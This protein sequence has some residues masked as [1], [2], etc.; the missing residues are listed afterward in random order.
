L[1]FGPAADTIQ[2]PA[3]VHMEVPIAPPSSHS[4]FANLNSGSNIAIGGC[5]TVG[6]VVKTTGA[7]HVDT[8]ANPIFPSV[9]VGTG[10]TLQGTSGIV[11]G[12]GSASTDK[13][14]VL[15]RQ[16][17]Q[18][19]AS[20]A[21]EHKIFVQVKEGPGDDHNATIQIGHSEP[22]FDVNLANALRVGASSTMLHSCGGARASF[23]R[24]TSVCFRATENQATSGTGMT[25]VG[26]LHVAGDAHMGRHV[27]FRGHLK[28]DID[29]NKGG[30]SLLST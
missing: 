20:S 29:E 18:V 10:G 30:Q 28:S 11:V 26:N 5:C 1:K 27:T 8:A 17:K 2:Q 12:T 13:G 16:G 23:H 15:F 24:N 19:Y 25:T 6:S 9:V 3:F 22:R 4:I 21:K 7:L 14:N